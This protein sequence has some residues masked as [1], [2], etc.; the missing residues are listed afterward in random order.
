MRYHLHSIKICMGYEI[1]RMVDQQLEELLP[2]VLDDQD[3]VM[4]IGDYLSWV[5]IDELLVE[6]PGLTKEG[7]IF[8][9]YSQLHMLLLSF[10]DTLIIDN[11]MRRDRQWLR[12]WRVVRPRPPDRSTFTTYNRSDVDRVRQTVE[13]LCMMVSIIGQVIVDEHRGLP[14]VISLTHEQLAEI[15]SDKIPSFPWDP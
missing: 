1:W 13:T 7:G 11:N 12:T 5:P 2:I 4:T 6:S 10:P 9:S 14:T 3:S 8:Q 15:R